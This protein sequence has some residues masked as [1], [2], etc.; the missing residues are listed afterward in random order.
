[1]VEQIVQVGGSLLILS[2]FVAA[3]QRRLDQDSWPYLALN[4][5]GSA[6]LAVLAFIGQ[7]WGFLLL[8]GVWAVVSAHGLLRA[9]RPGP[10]RGLTPPSAPRGWC[11]GRIRVRRAPTAAVG[12]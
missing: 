3:Q 4:L 11:L 6:I 2:A 5:A 7:Q 9:A 12:P 8:E 1:M 10:P